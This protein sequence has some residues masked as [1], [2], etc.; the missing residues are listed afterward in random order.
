[1]IQI[2][3]LK[4]KRGEGS[5]Y[6]I[7]VAYFTAITNFEAK[8]QKIPIEMVNRAS[9]GHN[10]PSVAATKASFRINTGI[11]PE[12]YVNNVL[13]KCLKLL[14]DKIDDILNEKILLDD[15]INRLNEQIEKYNSGKRERN[16]KGVAK[17]LE[18]WSQ[19]DTIIDALT[20]NGDSKGNT[21]SFQIIRLNAYIDLLSDFVHP[22]LINDGCVICVQPIRE[23]L[24]KLQFDQ[25]KTSLN[26]TDT[27]Y[28][29]YLWRFDASEDE[30]IKKD[31]E[32]WLIIQKIA[33]KFNESD[34]KSKLIIAIKYK[35]VFHLYSSLEESNLEFIK[36]CD[37]QSN[38]GYGSDSECECECELTVEKKISIR[39]HF[40]K[41]AD[42]V[43]FF[44]K[45]IVVA[46]GMRAII[47]AYLLAKK[48][49]AAEKFCTKQMYYETFN[50]INSVKN[51][52][53]IENFNC[54]AGAQKQIRFIDLNHCASSSDRSKVD[55]RKIYAE[56]EKEKEN[57]II[58]DHT[59]TTSDNLHK[60]VRM[61]IPK[62]KV[63]LLVSSGVKN[64]QIGA[65]NNPYGTIRIISTNL[66]LL[67]KLYNSLIDYL[68]SRNEKQ[69][70]RL[71]DVR[72]AYK[73]IG[74]TLT[75]KAIFKNDFNK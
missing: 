14:N 75:N 25:N 36:N 8:R 32:F 31:H 13:V 9:F 50:A 18:Q 55:F 60:I 42:K 16:S 35:K 20:K 63:L 70:K 12:I 53:L 17:V 59:S 28:N 19:E 41:K 21:I 34:A 72:K 67:Q 71:H 4:N 22:K 48:L 26:I 7:F 6:K 40:S 37:E 51:D 62:V 58:F 49:T 23:M 3:S 30:N 10:I 68:D 33:S 52:N 43:K 45:K 29:Q 44:C 54:Y 57:V 38:D 2:A 74:A 61:F 27:V 73:N 11:V 64:E 5:L 65:D 56:S 15:E 47:L 66:E 24:K 46:N 39:D 69:P 1:M